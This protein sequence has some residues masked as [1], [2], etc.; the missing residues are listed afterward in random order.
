MNIS[1]DKIVG[2]YPTL[3]L[4]LLFG[5][6]A[7]GDAEISSD[8]DFGYIAETDFNSLAFYSDLVLLMGTEKIDF[9]DLKRASGLLRFRATQDGKVIFERTPGEYEKFWLQAVHF[10]CDA[11]PMIRRE[12]DAL[13]ERLK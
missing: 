13:L 3:K 10:W 11:G 2:H 6:R 9:V 1:L 5:S 7:R 8:W 4:I 12:Y